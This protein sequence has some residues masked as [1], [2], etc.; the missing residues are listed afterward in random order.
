MK[1]FFSVCIITLSMKISSIYQNQYFLKNL[2]NKN[3]VWRTLA[4]IKRILLGLRRKNHNER[5]T[6]FLMLWSDNNHPFPFLFFPLSS[7]PLPTQFLSLLPLF[8][9]LFPPLT[10]SFPNI[11][12]L[13]NWLIDKK[14]FRLSC[15]FHKGGIILGVFNK[16][17]TREGHFRVF[18]T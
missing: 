14:A 3:L 7:L 13:P 8:P 4:W 1:P 10:P 2:R 6:T 17:F 5:E 18:S 9:D 12:G 11:I 16:F 15:I